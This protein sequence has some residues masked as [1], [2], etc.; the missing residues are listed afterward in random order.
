MNDKFGIDNCILAINPSN[1]SFAILGAV[2]MR[3]YY[4]QFDVDHRR[5]GISPVSATR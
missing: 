2:F 4:T 3:R 1:E 5:I